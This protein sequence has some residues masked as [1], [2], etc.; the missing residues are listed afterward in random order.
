MSQPRIVYRLTETQNNI[1]DLNTTL[2]SQTVSFNDEN[3]GFVQRVASSYDQ[4]RMIADNDETDLENFFARPIILDEFQWS[5]TTRF[6]QFFDPWD[7]FIMNPRVANRMSNYHLLKGKLHVR[8]QV[9]GNGFYYGRILANYIPRYAADDMIFDRALIYADNVEASQRPKIYIDPTLNEGGDIVCPFLCPTDT[10]SLVE[11]DWINMGRISMRE[12][13]QLRHANGNTD[14][15][16]ITVLAWMEDVVLSVPTNNNIASLPSQ[17]GLEVLEPQAGV[18]KRRVSVKSNTSSK[19]NKSDEYGTG[20][21]S[22]PA[23]TVARIAGSLTNAPFIGPYAKATEIGANALANVAR[24]FGYSRA[25][26]LE[27]THMYTPRFIPNM[28]NTNTPDTSNKLALDCKQEL[29]VDPAVVGLDCG[30]DE[31]T[32]QSITTR[33]SLIGK[34]EWNQA[35]LPGQILWSLGVSPNYVVQYDPGAGDA[36]EYHSTASNFG[37]MPFRFWRGSIRYRFQIVCSAYHKGRLRLQWDPHSYTGQEYN[38]QHT[39]VIDIAQ[40]TDFSI[41]IGWGSEFGWLYTTGMTAPQKFA[42]R[43]A[44]TGDA[45]DLIYNGVLTMSVQNILTAPNASAGDVVEVNC[46]VSTCDDFEV[47]VPDCE[48][49]NN[50]TYFSAIAPGAGLEAIEDIPQEFLE[51]QSGVEQQGDM[52]NTE[53]PSRPELWMTDARK[54]EKLD[55]TDA[56]TLVY[57]GESITSFRNCLKRYCNIGFVPLANGSADVDF[58]NFYHNSFPPLPG[59]IG[60]DASWTIDATPEVNYCKQSLFSYLSPAYVARR[61]GSRWKFTYLNNKADNHTSAIMYAI[62][63]PKN[64]AIVSGTTTVSSSTLANTN[65]NNSSLLPNTWCGAEATHCLVNPTVEVEVP[66]Q[67]QRRFSDARRVSSSN[68]TGD[69]FYQLSLVSRGS[70]TAPPVVVAAHAAAEDLSLHMYIGPP[71]MYVNA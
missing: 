24:I 61:G 21:V 36:I 30:V 53:E 54:G 69:R 11:G 47:A 1:L 56:A 12:L 44:F 22:G 67:T 42:I 2:R 50:I 10:I 71:V 64:T 14:A 26:T 3:P 52:E 39:H 37:S 68:S 35:D 23:S 17:G 63:G 28:A 58:Y 48:N 5:T 15:I 6:Y 43:S 7:L 65:A 33:E 8:F 20:P 59:P 51:P 49:V 4:T 40:E 66:F 13:N 32:I 27:P 34:A 29:T 18:R 31:M 62:G 46:F 60:L 38:V 19:S 9:N 41:D 16:T 25:Q 55:I 45:S 70:A 57:H